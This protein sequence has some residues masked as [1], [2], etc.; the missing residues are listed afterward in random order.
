MKGSPQQRLQSVMNERGLKQIDILRLSEPL[1]EKYGISMNKNHLS[2]YIN[3]KSNPDQHKTFLLAKTLGV[4]E[5]WIMGY[6]V[7]MNS[8]PSNA[9]DPGNTIIKIPVLGTIACGEPILADENVSEYRETFDRNLPKGKLF[10]LQASGDSMA[11]NIPDG[12]YVLLR[13]QE[14]VESGEIAAVLVNGDEEAT[15]KRVRKLGDSILL[16]AINENYAPYLI[17]E[18]S[19]ARIIGKAVKVEYEL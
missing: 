5:A 2:N 18:N 9:I 16:E 7:P 11:P 15:L 6:D 4:D 13:R 3:G 10:Y 1:Q 14:D 12:S 19:P 8:V 17:N